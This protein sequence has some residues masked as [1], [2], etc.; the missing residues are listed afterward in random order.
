MKKIVL[1][2][3]L[4]S[5]ILLLGGCGEKKKVEGNVEGKLSDLILKVYDGI[6]EL[7]KLGQGEVTED[8]MEYMLG[9]SDLDIKEAYYSEP[10]MTSIAHSV[11]LAR[12]NEGA[13]ID[14][15]KNKIKENINPRKWVCVEVDPQNVIV[16][17]KGDLIILI[18]DNEK[19]QAIHENFK[20]L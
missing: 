4:L 6:E 18:M 2:L 1:I 11:V 19:A 13:D 9:S 7:P 3:C 10:V 8:K 14:E 15:I 16:D 5:S 17:S 12:A 20:N